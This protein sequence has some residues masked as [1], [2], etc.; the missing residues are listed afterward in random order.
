MKDYSANIAK[1]ISKYI[2]YIRAVARILIF[3]FWG[4]GSWGNINLSIKTIIQNL[5]L[6]CK[7]L[8][9]FKCF[10]KLFINI[11]IILDSF[12]IF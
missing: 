1:L 6:Y 8:S 11:T 3:F 2:L 7:F 10:E 5:T 12:A 4:G 9:C